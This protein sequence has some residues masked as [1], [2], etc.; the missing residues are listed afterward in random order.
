MY[1]DS[2][3]RMARAGLM[4]SAAAAVWSDVVLNGAGG[5][6]VRLL[7]STFVTVAVVA[8]RTWLQARSAAAF[9]LK[10]AVAW[11]ALNEW[12]SSESPAGAILPEIT[13]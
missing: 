5:R 4:P 3:R 8:S 7:R 9:S 1:S 10:R 11:V 2:A 13:Q 6:V 12:A